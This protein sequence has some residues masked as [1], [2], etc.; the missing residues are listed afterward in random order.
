MFI[1]VLL[2]SV[3]RARANQLRRVGIIQLV[4]DS[5]VK[6]S[7]SATAQSFSSDQPISGVFSSLLSSKNKPFLPYFSLGVKLLHANFTFGAGLATNNGG[8]TVGE[9]VQRV[10]FGVKT[11]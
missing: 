1:T 6:D 10:K 11:G 2:L 5:Q 3:G 8:K 4:T 9:G 7:I